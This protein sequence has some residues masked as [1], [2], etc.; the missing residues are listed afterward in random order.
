M[1]KDDLKYKDI[2]KLH[3]HHVN[4]SKVTEISFK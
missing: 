4:K 1:Y 3:M 2:L